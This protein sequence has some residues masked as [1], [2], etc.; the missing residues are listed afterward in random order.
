MVN[1]GRFGDFYH[2]SG[3]AACEPGHRSP[4]AWSPENR[5]AK[6][7][8]PVTLSAKL[9]GPDRICPRRSVV[10][11]LVKSVSAP[12]RDSS[13]E[14]FG[15]APKIASPCTTPKLSDEVPLRNPFSI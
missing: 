10:V 3:R 4:A 14:P 1:H 6:E 9:S 8:C 7:Y 15:L 2:G 11:S 13:G 5:G 12:A